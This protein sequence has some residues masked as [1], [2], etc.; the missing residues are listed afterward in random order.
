M[1]LDYLLFDATD[2]ESG[3]ASFDALASVLPDRVPALL[4]E[5]EAVLQWAHREFGPPSAADAAGWDFDLQ[6]T[7]DG[8]VLDLAYD[9]V[10]GR[11]TLHPPGTGRITL[12]L[13]LGG[14]ASFG[15]AFRAAF[16]DAA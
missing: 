10:R 15:D 11:I 1:P 6:G 5:V 7:D 3:G 9:A 4:R 13:T 2:E 14:P 16:P 12:S 8:G